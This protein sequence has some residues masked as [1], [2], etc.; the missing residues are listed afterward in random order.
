MLFV[1]IFDDLV[2]NYLASPVVTIGTDV[3][4]AMSFTG[5]R[6]YRQGCAA[7]GVM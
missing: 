3:M 2:R 7:K 5:G 1:I 4:T 6:L